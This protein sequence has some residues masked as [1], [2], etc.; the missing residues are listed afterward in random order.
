M[1]HEA[2]ARH[3]RCPAMPSG[4]RIRRASPQSDMHR[5]RPALSSPPHSACSGWCWIL[6]TPVLSKGSPRSTWRLFTKMTPP[7][8]DRGGLLNAFFGSVVMSL[9]GVAHRHADRRARRH[10]PCRYGSTTSSPSARSSASSTTSCC[11]RRRSCS[12]CS[13]T[14]WSSCRWAHFSG[15][16]GA[17]ALAFIVLPVVVR[18]TD[19]MLRLVP[20]HAARGRARARR[21]ALEGDPLHRLPR[22]AAGHRHRRP[23]GRWRASP[24]RPRRCCSPRSTTSSGAPT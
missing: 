4:Q 22:R 11:R 14:R 5:P 16:A 15:F 8:G 19:D 18:T 2:I 7:P 17:L 23:A 20:A 24:A 13:S 9:L 12:A 21:A 3:G 6:W 10:L 1:A